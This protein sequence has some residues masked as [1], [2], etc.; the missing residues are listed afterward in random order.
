MGVI[1]R[2]HIMLSRDH[3]GH[4]RVFV[5]SKDVNLRR[6][7]PLIWG[8]GLHKACGHFSLSSLVNS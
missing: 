8:N 6:G 2:E 5:Q 4:M 7:S 3:Y 1:F